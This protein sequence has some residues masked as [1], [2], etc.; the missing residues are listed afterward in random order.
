M[1]FE[2]WN[3]DRNLAFKIIEEEIKSFN[4]R[5]KRIDTD[6][7]KEIILYQWIGNE[8]YHCI[9]DI[10][11]LLSKILTYEVKYKFDKY[12]DFEPTGCSTKKFIIYECKF[13][14]GGEY[15]T[16]YAIKDYMDC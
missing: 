4:D 10:I 12:T 5:I 9:N 3:N 13:Y 8:F 15:L 7:K 1:D 16:S 2:Q 11:R 6:L 14:L